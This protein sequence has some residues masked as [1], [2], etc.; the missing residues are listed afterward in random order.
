MTAPEAPDRTALAQ[1]LLDLA[2]TQVNSHALMLMD[3]QG[4][5]VAWLAGCERLFGYRPEEIVGRDASV[6]FTPED[7]TQ[8]IPAWEMRTAC[9]S[10]EAED[11]RWQ[12]RKDGV[13]IWVSGSLTALR[14]EAGQ[15]LGYAKIM[16]DTTYQKGQV[17]ALDSR[18]DVLHESEQRRM[19]FTSTLAHELRT[20]LSV[21]SNAADLLQMKA[22]GSPEVT[23]AV[24]SVRRQVDFM[25][26][27]VNDLM[28]IARSA[29]GKVQLQVERISL[30][31]ILR[32]ACEA[33]A[34]AIAQR[35]QRLHQLTPEA[36][37][38][39]EADATRMRQVF[40][41]LVQNACKYT[42]PGG[43]IW[44]KATTEGD[45]A[46]I[47]V[48]DNGVGIAPDVMPHIF[49]M[50]AQADGASSGLGIGLA[51]V[52]EAVT[53]HGG[54][55]QVSSDGVNKGSEFTVRLPLPQQRKP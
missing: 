17:E 55:V 12:M 35:R 9:D 46:V 19:Q 51:V 10:P 29:L 43:D 8:G 38:Y 11:D 44:V 24:G 1:R 5:V 49:D 22:H 23:F 45:E 4:S 33:C 21:I 36:P 40:V 54:T 28:E 27:M 48:A 53:L 52:K 14:D 26:R 39:V 16:R 34:P 30:Q 50:F 47:K 41:N 32:D 37:I 6:L 7:I 25:N 31:L 15:L 13:R 18:I 3:P 42:P 2:P 20:P